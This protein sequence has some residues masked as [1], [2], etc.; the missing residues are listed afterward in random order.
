[1]FEQIEKQEVSDNGKEF[2]DLYIKF[3]KGATWINEMKAKGKNIDSEI[4]RYHRMTSRMDSIWKAL[5]DTEKNTCA[6]I[7]VD[8][9]ILPAKVALAI[10]L[11]NGQVESL[12]AK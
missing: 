7:L 12:H 6:L 3:L 9:G 5:P 4:I 2:M 10:E 1:M 8:Q 11:F